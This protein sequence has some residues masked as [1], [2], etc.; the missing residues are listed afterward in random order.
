MTRAPQKRRLET[1]ARLLSVAEG[2]AAQRGYAGLRAEEVVS[3]AGV[4]KG[5]LFSHFKDMDGLLA[6]LIGGKVMALLDKMEQAAPPQTPAQICALLNDQLEFV[7]RERVIF[8]V[9]LRYSGVTAAQAEEVISEGFMR[10]VRI[11]EGWIDAMQKAG[12]I[13]SDQPASLLAEGIQGFLNHILAVWFCA[14]HETGDTPQAALEP[15][16]SAWLV[17]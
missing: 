11:L 4:A 9:L 16:I 12:T 17:T 15:Y 5:T 3:L 10:Q 1:R 8:D 2:I 13:R 6:L 14:E 7:A